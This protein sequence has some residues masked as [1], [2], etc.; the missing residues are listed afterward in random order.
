MQTI[1]ECSGD[2][3]FPHLEQRDWH[4]Q[5][6]FRSHKALLF[7]KAPFPARVTFLFLVAE[8]CATGCA[9][10]V[11]PHSSFSTLIKTFS[12]PHADVAIVM[13]YS[14]HKRIDCTD[15]NHI[16]E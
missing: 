9:S 5:S 16:V 14:L 6:F 3:C 8:T 15:I 13:M 1:S 7:N 10:S 11:I 4:F 12:L 2:T